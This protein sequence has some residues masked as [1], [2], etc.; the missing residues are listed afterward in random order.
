MMTAGLDLCTGLC[1][2][3]STNQIKFFDLFAF[4]SNWLVDVHK[5]I[6]L[7]SHA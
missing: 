2:G 7:L 5:L 1:A 4:L 3:A 6:V